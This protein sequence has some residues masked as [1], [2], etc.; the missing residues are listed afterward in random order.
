MAAILVLDDNDLFRELAVETL[1]RAGHEV[2]SAPDGRHV[3]ESLESSP[4]DLV[5]TDLMMP[6]R[7]GVETIMALR[8]THPQ[9]PVIAISGDSSV[10]A[11]LCLAIASRL[12]VGYTLKKP[13]A[14]AT[15]L[16]TV[17]K[18]LGKG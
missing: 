13:F 9:L 2:R 11:A 15:L 17:D 10:S 8:Q 18:A 1:R 12:G 3:V 16:A 5:I 7:D 4:V 6:N 14:A